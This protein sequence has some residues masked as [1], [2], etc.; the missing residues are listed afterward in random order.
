MP[1]VSAGREL[2][3]EGTCPFSGRPSSSHSPAAAKEPDPLPS[4]PGPDPMPILGWRGNVG[5]HFRD[6]L[7]NMYRLRDRFGNVSCLVQGGN[8]PL[9]FRPDGRQASTVFGFG[10]ECN[11]E[12]LT[13]PDVFE[14][15]F[16]R[17]PPG[18]D[19]LGDNMVAANRDRRA[20]ERRLMSG[21]L[22]RNHLESY[23]DDM[24][25]LTE[26]MLSSWQVDQT[27]RLV[28]ELEDLTADIASKTFYGQDPRQEEQTLAAVAR[29]TARALFSPVSMI[30]IDLPGSPYRRF[31]AL[32]GRAEA[33]I[34]EEIGKKREAG[35]PGDDV[36][37]MMIR[38]HDEGDMQLSTGHLVGNAFALFLAGHDVPANALGFVFL[39]LAQHPEV[40][41]DLQDELDARLGG[42]PPTMDQIWKDLPVLDQVIRES[43]RVLCPAILLWRRVTSDTSL[44]GFAIP[45]GTEVVIS[46]FMTHRDPAIYPRADCFLPSRWQEIR[47]TPFEYL[48]YSYGARKCLGMA[49]VEML[50]KIVVSSTLQRYRL[51]MLPRNRLDLQVT[52]TMK[53]KNS[54]PMVIRPQDREFARSKGEVAGRVAE[55]VSFT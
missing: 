7:G 12:V 6:P 25:S 26:R 31:L 51:E 54:L 37:S 36:L 45:A 4:P 17:S 39:L 18:H 43:M 1:E 15:D 33:V 29:D 24:V 32:V 21:A 3:K 10:P 41:A 8:S 34:R 46:P 11:C 53:P 14:S 28:D 19:W 20:A 38:A 44:G 52:F 49:F 55:L 48:P 42:R 47:P 9:V 5:R 22:T 30:P 23:Y 2:R 35:T 16:L 27:V 50:L 13:Q 40:A